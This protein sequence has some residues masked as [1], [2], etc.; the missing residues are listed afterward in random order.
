MANKLACVLDDFVL[1]MT[2]RNV[3]LCYILV[4][5]TGW[6]GA[7]VL[8]VPLRSSIKC[9]LWPRATQNYVFTGI[10]KQSQSRQRSQPSF[11]EQSNYI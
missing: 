6:C 8:G 3:L 4:P 10:Y 11:P 1:G 9:L 7:H 2:G 5:L